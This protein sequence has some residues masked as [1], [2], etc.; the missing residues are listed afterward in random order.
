MIKAKHNKYARHIF[1]S[2]LNKILKKDFSHFFIINEIPELPE[3]KAVLVTPNHIS[4]WD[5]FFIDYINR[6]YFKRKIFIMML[7]EQLK[8]YKYFSMVGAYSINPGHSRDVIQ[9]LKYTGELL[10]DT[11]NIVI[12]YPEGE[13]KPFNT[14][15]GDLKKGLKKVTVNNSSSFSVLPVAFKLSF[16]NERKP[17]IYAYFGPVI[18]SESIK[19]NFSHYETIFKETIESVHRASLNRSYLKDLFK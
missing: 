3:D 12:F 1:S 15:P 16:Y 18:D 9:S 17:E 6:H 5:G 4:W 2:Y 11:K 7:E 14:D 8:I 19:N 13:L 10:S